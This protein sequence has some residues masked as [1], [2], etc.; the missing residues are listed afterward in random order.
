MTR[1]IDSHSHLDMKDFRQDLGQVLERARENGVSR[2]ISIGIDF[3]SS[4]RAIHL[5]AKHEEIFAT[6]GYH[7]HNARE[8]GAEELDRLARLASEPKVVAWGEIGLDF[9]HEYSPPEEQLA[10][11]SYQLEQAHDLHLP[12]VIHDRDAHEETFRMLKRMGKG[13]RKGVIHCFSGDMVLA[14]AFVELGYFV[15]L[16]GTVTY[17][18]AK[19]AR[20]VAAEIPIDCLLIET[21]APFLAPVP[22][23]GKRNEPGFVLHTAQEIARLRDMDFEEVARRTSENAMLL[24]RLPE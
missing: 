24:F 7:P 17:K 14:R 3:E 20:E 8:G 16:P 12:V 23:R 1:L 4:R 6:V 18:G 2:I 19:A 13:E 15:S 10:S 5:A 9:Y 21:D 11:F 22:M